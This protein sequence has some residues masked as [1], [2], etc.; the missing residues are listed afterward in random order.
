M[1]PFFDAELKPVD[2]IDSRRANDPHV[3]MNASLIRRKQKH[4]KHIYRYSYFQPMIY[5][6]TAFSST[7]FC[8]GS[9]VVL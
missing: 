5:F 2:A 1:I 9:M 4:G 6:P 8:A 3:G 7:V